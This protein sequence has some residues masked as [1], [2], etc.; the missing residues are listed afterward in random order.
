MI[1]GDDM[2]FLVPDEAG[3]LPLI[4]KEFVGCV[5]VIGPRHEGMKVKIKILELSRI[6]FLGNANIHDRRD[7]P[8]VNINQ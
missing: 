4:K 1:I 6:E 3:A 2:P 8:L 5:G 7:R